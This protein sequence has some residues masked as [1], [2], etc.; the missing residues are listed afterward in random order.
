MFRVVHQGRTVAHRLTWD[1]TVAA[2]RDAYTAGTRGAV[3]VEVLAPTGWQQT[4]VV[5]GP[6][7][8]R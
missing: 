8:V 3:V 6:T 4:V 5:P 1:G 2:V 7:A